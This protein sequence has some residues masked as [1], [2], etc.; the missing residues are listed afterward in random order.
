[1]PERP[2][3]V[4]AI[5]TPDVWGEPRWVMEVRAGGITRSPEHTAGASAAVE[6][7]TRP[8]SAGYA[9]RFPRIVRLR[10]GKRAE[11][12]TTEAEL[13]EL[14]QLAGSHAT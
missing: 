8:R 6:T 12:A 13:V 10:D 9:L 14:V 11:D 7:G 5:L 1:M 4:E 3:Q 2:A